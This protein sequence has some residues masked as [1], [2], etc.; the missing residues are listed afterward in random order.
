MGGTVAP[1]KDRRAGATDLLR[2]T[3][4]GSVDDGKSTLIGRLLYETKT[5]FE[6]QLEQVE[7]AS[8]RSG[9]KEVNLALLTDGLRA[10]REQKITIDV[11]YRYFATPRRKFIIADTPG[12]VQY[13]RNMVTGASTADLAIILV[14][15]RKGVVT[16]SRRHASLASLLG[17][18][19]LVVAVNKMD[20]VGYREDAYREIV[21]DFRTFA[22]KLDLND[23]T[24]VP[25]SALRGDHVVR[26]SERMPWYQDGSL[27]EILE[28]VEV[29]PGTNETDFRLP[30][31]YVIR[32][33]P[34]FRGYTGTVASGT[35]RP[36]D[37]VVAL[38]AGVETR[39]RTV[40]TTAGP[41]E[42]AGAG[43]AV[44][45]TLED[46]VDVSRGEMIAQAE[47][48]PSPA[49]RFRADLCWMGEEPA[50]P[51]ES[52]RL[53]HTTREVQAVLDQ[54]D[55]RL[56]P[57]TLEPKAAER[58]TLNDIGR[59]ELTTAAPLF[60]DPYGSN[61]ATGNFVLVDP[62]TNRTVGAGMIRGSREEEDVATLP[63]WAASED[64][65]GHLAWDGWSVSLEER[66]ERNGH[67][68][69][70]LWLTGLPGSG[71]TTLGRALERRLF[72]EGV[73]SF[74]LDGDHVRQGLGRDLGFSEQDR[75]E[76]LRR[77]GQVA[78]LLF[79]QGTLVI[80]SFV[81]PF[82]K[83]REAVRSLLPEGRFFEVFVSCGVEE[84]IR[85][86]PKGLYRKALDGEIP[87]FT[88]VS[89]PYEEPEEPE[90]V[91]DTAE[92]TVDEVAEE[93]V[94]RLREEGLLP[95]R[96]PAAGSC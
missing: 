70:V 8:R 10:E 93:I 41:V 55:H 1:P 37:R 6:D 64:E 18:R 92:R 36:G 58:L 38:P 19:H 76:N 16:Q 63:V 75:R 65:E 56:D 53:L 78:R 81:S 95:V 5:V 29:D 44:V 21:E 35:V 61:P 26:P 40:E 13:T 32:P 79:Q 22:G 72:E 46:E 80:C 3:T 30:V 66:E 17:I 90:L 39:V 73:Q 62:R 88:G 69:A 50:A 31:Q 7:G 54:V 91:A 71:K 77:V 86:D 83:D 28:T 2:F 49:T 74:Q 24:F 59:V 87:G 89:A 42:S 14:D 82:R 68:A 27:L 60:C 12:H 67:R 85:R 25:I 23:L 51:G 34:E 9:E 57:D 96:G 52:Y 84:C 11:A 45:V 94:R 48:A 47:G 15:A 4:A 43:K 20:L 33:N